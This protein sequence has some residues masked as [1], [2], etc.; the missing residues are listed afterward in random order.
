MIKNKKRKHKRLGNGDVIH[1]SPKLDQGIIIVCGGR[2]FNL[3][4]LI[5]TAVGSPSEIESS[6]KIPKTFQYQVKP[7]HKSFFE[8]NMGYSIGEK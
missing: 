8:R 4:N 6:V 2:R 1:I 7:K 3:Q 5:F